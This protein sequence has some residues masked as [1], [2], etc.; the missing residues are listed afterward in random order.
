MI[1][2]CP[3]CERPHDIHPGE[4]DC[5]HIA[6]MPQ[7]GPQTLFLSLRWVDII[8]YGGSAG[9]GKS[10]ALLLDPVGDLSHSEFHGT[11]FRRESVQITN[12]GGLWDE[13]QKVYRFIGGKARTSPAHNWT[14]PSGASLTMTHLN[15]EDD[16]YGHQG[17]QNS[18]QG[19]DEL[20]HF[21]ERQFWYLQSRGRSA[22][23]LGSRTRA[24]CNPDA[25]SWVKRF[26]GPW[27]DDSHRDKARR[28]GEVRWLVRIDP[29]ESE[30]AQYHYFRTKDDAVEY[31]AEVHH[32]TA[33][34]ARYAVKSVAFIE[35]DINDNKMLMQANP[36]YLA[37]LLSLPEV[38][39][40]RLLYKNW[41]IL[42]DTFFGDW[43]PK[44][45]EGRPWHVL[46]TGPVPGGCRYYIG[47]DWGYGSPCAHYL[48]AIDGNGRLTVCR[49]VYGTKM[50]TSEQGEAMIGMIEKNGLKLDDVVVYAGHDVFNGRL[51]SK[52]VLDEPISA[53]WINEQHLF[54]QRAGANPVGRASKYREYLKDWGVDEGWADGRPGLQVMDCC[55]N[56]I[57]TFPLLKSDPHNPEMYDTEMEDHAAD[58]V[59]HILT[60]IPAKPERRDHT[61]SD[62]VYE[63][64]EPDAVRGSMF[65]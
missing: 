12:E 57:R 37:N 45:P 47:T 64:D 63:Q 14:F 53:T 18:W 60:S 33:D 62:E 44:T 58:A 3:T 31:A 36:E 61:V 27:V 24:T 21:T 11:L 23:G 41:N 59:G 35:A 55:V 6:I 2:T 30:Q 25:G 28:N 20:T 22:A 50:R 48:V 46:P 5:G 16:I 26:L 8:V 1:A 15:S 39:K 10:W 19:W 56:F 43:M 49:E 29:S 40:Q 52:G 51:N 54:V 7:D 9:S 65:Y 42:T 4:H 17:S 34:V 32:L 38:E 13:S